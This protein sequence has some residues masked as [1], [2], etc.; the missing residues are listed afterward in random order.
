MTWNLSQG[1]LATSHSKCL[2]TLDKMKFSDSVITQFSNMAVLQ[3]HQKAFLDQHCVP[4]RR[5]KC[6]SIVFDLFQDQAPGA[7]QVKEVTSEVLLVYNRK[8]L[9]FSIILAS[10]KCNATNTGLVL[11]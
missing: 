4:G 5:P 2:H 7:F 9:H 3:K 6:K 8:L 1:I 10:P 11:T